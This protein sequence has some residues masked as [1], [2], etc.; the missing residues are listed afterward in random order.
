MLF[1]KTTPK[2]TGAEFWGDCNDLECLYKTMSKLATLTDS[3][4]NSYARNE[5]LL[6]II[7]YDLRHAYQEERLV[8]HSILNGVDTYTTYYGF[9][10]DWITILYTISALRYNAGKVAT[11]ELDQSN[12]TQFEYWTRKAFHEFDPKGA[13]SI[14]QF[15]NRRIDVSTKYVY[16]IHQDLVQRYFSMKPNKTRFRSI[17]HLLMSMG[18]GQ[19]LDALIK[20]V[21]LEAKS[22]G[23]NV[24]DLECDDI[25][26]IIW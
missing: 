14:E 20:Q 18:Y 15:I 1:A 8:N 17:P 7:P 19:E 26:S 6:S 13:A 21:E 22:F 24:E 5:Q 9:R 10:A 2:G 3:S 4:E 12:L 25:T 11:D 16:L 23:C